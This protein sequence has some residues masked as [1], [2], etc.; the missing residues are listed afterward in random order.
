MTNFCCLTS[1]GNAGQEIG[2]G[3]EDKFRVVIRICTAKRNFDSLQSVVS[4]ETPVR[5]LATHDNANSQETI[6]C[7]NTCQDLDTGDH[8]RNTSS[9]S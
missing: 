5:R 9:P 3:K 7:I 4:N 1:T 6:F 2:K 8:R